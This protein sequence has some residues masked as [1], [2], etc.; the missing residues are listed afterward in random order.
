MMTMMVW[1]AVPFLFLFKKKEKRREEN[2]VGWLYGGWS[3]DKTRV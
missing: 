3:S 1:L 2:P